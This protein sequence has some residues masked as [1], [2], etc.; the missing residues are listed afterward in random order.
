LSHYENIL[1]TYFWKRRCFWNSSYF[2]TTLGNVSKIKIEEY[3]ENQLYGRRI[4]LPK[5]TII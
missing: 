3:L 4:P 2:V 5:G 1:I